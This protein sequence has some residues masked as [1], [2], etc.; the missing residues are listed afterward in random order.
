MATAKKTTKKTT[1]A[2]TKTTKKADVTTAKDDAL[3]NKNITLQIRNTEH[4]L[5]LRKSKGGV[6]VYSS[7]DNKI[8]LQI[9]K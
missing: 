2:A 8:T 4:S 1:K 6:M 7:G 9:Q 3:G 5:E